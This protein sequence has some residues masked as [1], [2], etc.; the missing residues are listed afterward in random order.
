MFYYIIMIVHI[1]GPS[2]SGKSYLGN[3]LQKKFGKKIKVKDLDQLRDEFINKNYDTSKSWSFSEKKYQ[4]YINNFIKKSKKPLIF[5]G[6]ND[7]HFG[8]TKSL[9]YNL[10]S[11]YNYYIDI[12]DTIIIK[13]KCERF[14]KSFLP[15]IY[16]DFKNNIIIDNKK[17]IEIV[18]KSAKDE[19]SASKT[20]ALNKK[21][22]KDYKKMGYIFMS[23]ES[24]YKK[25]STLLQ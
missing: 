1:S 24:I 20:I 11:D 19:C 22:S 14:I 8:K 10:Q 4:K 21:W 2:G 9:Y 16:N 15:D 13:Q 17:F 7:N 3:K 12:D 5:V 18:T 23:R 25:V 6:L